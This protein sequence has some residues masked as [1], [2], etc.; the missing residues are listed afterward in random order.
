MTF[1]VVVLIFI[2]LPTNS[3]SFYLNSTNVHEL[4]V[5]EFNNRVLNSNEIWIIQFYV[6][7]SPYCKK[8]VDEYEKA[9]KALKGFVKL[10]ALN[11][12]TSVDSIKKYN[13]NEYPTIKI[14]N[15]ERDGASFDYSFS[16]EHTA[17][18]VILDAMKAI[19]KRIDSELKS[20][21]MNLSDGIVELNDENF[22]RTV[23]YSENVWI[24]IFYETDSEDLEALI[25]NLKAEF[26]NNKKIKI[27]IVGYDNLY[28]RSNF[29]AHLLPKIVFLPFG[30]QKRPIHYDGAFAK[31]EVIRF[32]EDEY[33]KMPVIKPNGIN[34][35]VDEESLYKL[36]DN[37]NLCVVIFL[38]E[39]KVFSHHKRQIYYGIFKENIA[40][41]RYAE[42]TWI[43]CEYGKIPNL[44]I[45]LGVDE[46][47]DE[48][49]VSALQLKHT[50]HS[51]LKGPFTQVELE[52]FLETARIGI[53][54]QEHV[55]VDDIY[56]DGYNKD[57]L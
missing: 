23:L 33:S 19:R 2:A 55:F 18:G 42:W 9:G 20:T 16:N 30:I 26:S 52:D 11:V 44:E 37:T 24:V 3:L 51:L 7:Q 27:G 50:S 39:L 8:F 46:I 36:C 29:D 43:W 53:V 40:K 34:E 47:D 38:P 32:V 12:A 1:L 54:E 45:I 14:F 28:L 5:D 31:D 56:S 35:A 15:H 4:T 22:E 48:P 49:T 21:L 10:G 13:L 6:K 17:H 25:N 41:Y 57:E